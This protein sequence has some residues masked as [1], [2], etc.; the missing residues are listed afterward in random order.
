MFE[1]LGVEHPSLLLLLPLALLPLLRR[2]ADAGT[3]SWLELIPP[4][5]LSDILGWLERGLAVFA[6]AA[7][8]LGLA[9]PQREEV[10]VERV[11]RG[12]EIVLLLDRSRSMDQPFATA[13]MVNWFDTSGETKGHAARRLLAEFTARRR[14]DAFAM[15]AFSTNPITV[16]PFTRQGEAVQAA[17]AAAGI[18]RGLAETDIGRGLLRAAS[19]FESR[20]Y[21]GSRIVLMV[22]DGGAHLDEDTRRRVAAAMKRSRIALYWIYIRS[23][24][25]P[26][27]TP[28]AGGAHSDSDLVPESAL[29]RYFGSMGTPY[30]AFEA[31]SADALQRAMAAVDQAENL[32]IVYTTRV[33]QLDLAPLCYGM[34]LLAALALTALYLL[35][36]RPWR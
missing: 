30:Q 11:G 35:E 28:A 1:N 29:H 36:V 24:G 10:P 18:G 19:L 5:P 32:P 22:S 17:I 16:L 20:P 15:V 6:I 8:V 34:A 13:A 21:S 3:F 27:L 4:D 26:G 33:P 23:F 12:A 7:T 14:N 2:A 31:E 25:S 9:G